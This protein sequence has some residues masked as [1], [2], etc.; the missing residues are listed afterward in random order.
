MTCDVN[1]IVDDNNNDIQNG[2]NPPNDQ[3]DYTQFTDNEL[4]R[5]RKF[6][7]DV[8]DY[9]SDLSYFSQVQE[10]VNSISSFS[11]SSTPGVPKTAPAIMIAQAAMFAWATREGIGG[12]SSSYS[13][14]KD[15]SEEA[16]V[17]IDEESILRDLD[18]ENPDTDRNGNPDDDGSGNR[19]PNSDPGSAGT[20]AANSNADECGSFHN[21]PISPLVIDLDGDG[22]ELVSIEDSSAN[23]DLDLD[24]FRERVSWVGADDG[25]LALDV[26]GNGIIDDKSELFGDSGVNANGFEALA[27]LDTNN[28]GQINHLDDEF[29]NLVIW[30][31]ADGDGITD[32]GE[33]SGLIENQID[34]ISLAATSINETN[35]GNFVSHRSTVSF[36]DG[37]QHDIDDVWFDSDRRINHYVLPEDF[38]YSEAAFV[39][40]RLYGYGEIKSTLVAFSERP[41]LA[42]LAE[43]LLDH[44]TAGEISEFFADMENFLLE[45]AEVSGVDPASR[46]VSHGNFVDARHLA[47]LEKYYGAAFYQEYET[48]GNPDSAAGAALEADYARV[49]MQFS[50]RFLSQSAVSSFLNGDI[51]NVADHPFE[52]LSKI[53]VGNNASTD[54]LSGE[55]DV[56]DLT[57]DAIQR[58]LQGDL[59]SAEAAQLIDLFS[60]DLFVSREKYLSVVRNTALTHENDVFALSV[61]NQIPGFDVG[62]FDVHRAEQFDDRLVTGDDADIVAMTSQIGAIRVLEWG[63]TNQDDDDVLV[64]AHGISL[65]DLTVSKAD[66][67]GDGTADDAVITFAGQSGSIIIEQAFIDESWYHERQIDWF[68]FSDGT[69]LSHEDFYAQTYFLGTI[70]DEVISGTQGDDTFHLGD[71]IDRIWANKGSDIFVH[72]GDIGELTIHDWG[73]G[74]AHDDDTL[75]FADGVTIDDIIAS[76]VGDTGDGRAHDLKI[77]VDGFIGAIILEEVFIEQSWWHERQIDWFEF[78][79]GTRLS[80]EDFYAQTIFQG[81]DGDD[82]IWGTRGNDAFTGSLGNERWLGNHGHDTYFI[83]KD[84]GD[85]RLIEWGN[86]FTD[87]IIF[88][89]GITSSD[90]IVERGDFDANGH[91]DLRISFANGT[92]SVTVDEVFRNAS[93]VVERRIDIYEF[94]DGTSLTHQE[95]IDQLIS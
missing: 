14:W 37:R 94:E 49:L 92:G 10:I 34:E 91:D 74:G 60:Y 30:V 9:S 8:R 25:L 80:H 77:E 85:D 58:A 67:T 11:S 33:L 95:I 42:L 51:A 31:D 3:P 54:G 61:V 62:D 48:D 87:T 70:G 90:L 50:A 41:D 6:M 64:F 43:A 46:A 40:P 55:A 29:D 4:D 72:S 68:E 35:E 47:F 89:Q 16:L 53:V 36:S 56:S 78:S 75:I 73:S 45:W 59:T 28:D 5:Y 21:P 27:D 44:A 2:N 20:D 1:S 83:D 71:G 69:R 65:S 57:L 17:Q 12:S 7:E 26:N 66:G 88:G 18:P 32:L 76:Q 79:D 15:F 39:L 13:N 63:T 22:V 38:S 93:W 86:N 19:S 82:R 24:G 84:Q 23:F 81:T 52:I